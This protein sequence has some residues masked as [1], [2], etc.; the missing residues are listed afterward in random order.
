MSKS[1]QN[2]CEGD[3]SFNMAEQFVKSV[4]VA[5]HQ[6]QDDSNRAVQKWPSKSILVLI[7]KPGVSADASSW[8][9]GNILLAVISP[10]FLMGNSFIKFRLNIDTLLISM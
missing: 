1:T 3:R 9:S 2:Y 7:A 10:Y 8:M 6:K 4:E 5:E